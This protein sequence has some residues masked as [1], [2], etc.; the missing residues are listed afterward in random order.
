MNADCRDLRPLLSAYMDNELTPEEL[1][2]VQAHVATCA[3]CAAILQEYRQ[4]RS[5]MRSLAQPVPPAALRAAVFAK[6]TPAYRRRAALLTFG[7]RGLSYAALTAAMIAILFT[8]ALLLRSGIGPVVG[9]QSDTTPPRIASLN[10]TPN[11]PT[12]GLNS[13]IRITFSEEM[14]RSS[15]IAAL[16]ITADPPLSDAERERLLKSATWEG[17]TLI[18]GGGMALQP[19]T[20]Y[21]ITINTNQ[22]R[23]KAQ[24]PLQGGNNEFQFRTVDVVAA[25]QTPT[26]IIASVPVSPSPLPSPTATARPSEVPIASITAAVPTQTPRPSSAAPVASVNPT[27]TSAAAFISPPPS[28]VPPQPT[29]TQTAVPPTPTATTPAPTPTAQPTNTP[30]PLPPTPT[31]PAP[32]APPASPTPTPVRSPFAVGQSFAAV[33]EPLTERLGLPTANETAVPGAYLAFE[34]GWMLWRGDTRTVYVLFN[35]NPLVWYAF[36]DGWVEGMEPGGGPT[37]QAGR[38]KPARGFGKVWAEN[39]DVQRRLGLALTPNETGGTIAVQPFERG[40]LLASNL[41]APTIYVFYQ[42]NTFEAYPR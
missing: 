38:Y 39:P 30:T 3:E 34:W 29:A 9:T 35:E 17:N 32:T 28:S 31:V 25:G 11:E 40:L 14:D 27:P 5:S 19:Y 41:G 20:D 26:A 13:P 23:D 6:A 16:R 37:T 22:A 42:N 36:A 10:P 1:R 8:A 24:N 15:V 2:V 4:V 7:Q 33:Y 21:T 18:I 12:W